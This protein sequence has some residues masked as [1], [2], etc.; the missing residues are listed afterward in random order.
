MDGIKKENLNVKWYCH[1]IGWNADSISNNNST[2]QIKDKGT[3]SVNVDVIIENM[4]FTESKTLTINEHLYEATIKARKPETTIEITSAKSKETIE[5]YLEVKIDG[6]VTNEYQVE[7]TAYCSDPE[8]ERSKKTFR[9]TQNWTNSYLV[10]TAVTFTNGKKIYL[11][12]T[13][14]IE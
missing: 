5:F 2:A 3:Y 7:W 12:T 14:K 1:T 10:T 11:D 8:S 4:N 6:I 13:F 9:C